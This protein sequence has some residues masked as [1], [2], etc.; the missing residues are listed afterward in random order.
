MIDWL[1]FDE[2]VKIL[3]PVHTPWHT[4]LLVLHD[5]GGLDEP[6]HAAVIISASHRKRRRSR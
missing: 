1:V 3:D 5:K 2:K 4:V 6:S